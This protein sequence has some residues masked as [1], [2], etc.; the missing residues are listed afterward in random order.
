MEDIENLM[1]AKY[2]CRSE[3]LCFKV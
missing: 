1:N 2:S 3:E